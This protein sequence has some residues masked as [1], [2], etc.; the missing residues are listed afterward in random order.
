[1]TSAVMVIA[2]RISSRIPYD[3]ESCHTRTGAAEKKLLWKINAMMN[4]M[5][6]GQNE[7]EFIFFIRNYVADWRRWWKRRDY[8]EVR[9]I[10]AM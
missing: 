9:E 4:I 8:K 7:I 5:Q 10:N 2:A 3:E 1:M 6:A